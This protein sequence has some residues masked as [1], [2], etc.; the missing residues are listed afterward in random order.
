VLG[1]VPEAIGETTDRKQAAKQASRFAHSPAASTSAISGESLS[2]T[3]LTT[4]LISVDAEALDDITLQVESTEYLRPRYSS[5]GL[6]VSEDEE[7]LV[8]K[9]TTE[10]NRPENI[11]RKLPGMNGLKRAR[12]IKADIK[13]NIAVLQ[14]PKKATSGRRHVED[15]PEN[16]LI[17]TLRQ[18][19]N[20]SWNNIANYLNQER[21]NRGEAA[22]FTDAAVYSRFVRNAPK[23]ATA[24]G[25]MGFDP[26]DYMHLRHPNQYT[27]AEGTGMLSK[28]GKKRIKNYDNA[29][30]LEANMRKQVKEDEHMELETA[31]KTEQLM[32]A[33]AK[34]ERNFWVLVADEMERATTKLYP[35]NVLASRYHAI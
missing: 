32:Q 20:M 18:E 28:V 23:I 11:L 1:R 2:S 25:E 24:V 16:Q 34:V 29:K 30:E 26:R 7:T 31:E 19:Q 14:S 10:L 13:D 12:A 17:K 5:Q 33:V 27:P 8:T 15:D 22:N 3:S 4:H 9:G 35:P 6:F 21:R